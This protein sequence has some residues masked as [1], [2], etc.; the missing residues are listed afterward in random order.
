MSRKRSCTSS[1]G[2][3]TRGWWRPRPT[4]DS[5]WRRFG[6]SSRMSSSAS[7]RSSTAS[8]GRCR[9]SPSTHGNPSVRCVRRSAP[10]PT[11]SSSGP[12]IAR[13]SRR[14]A[15]DARV[16][17]AALD[18]RAT[19]IAVHASRGGAGATFVATHLARAFARRG[20]STVLIDADLVYGEVGAAVGAPD[21][22]VHTLADLVPLGAELTPAHLDETFWTHP[23]AFR[24]LLS[25]PA[26]EAPSIEASFLQRVVDVAATSTDVVILHLPHAIDAY[27]RAGCETADRIVEVLTLDVLSF[28]S[29]K[30]ALDV[31]RPLRDRGTA[32]VRREPRIA[33]RDHAEGRQPRVR[34]RA[35]GGRAA[36]SGRDPCA[37]PRSSRSGARTDGSRVRSSRSGP[38]AGGGCVEAQPPYYRARPRRPTT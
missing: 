18:R 27:A 8:P 22:D 16:G 7:R 23:E 19:V 36:R 4:I 14:A 2:A 15:A 9:S 10:A 11:A 24:V 6:N 30:R 5:C 32:R 25:P 26:V 12:P 17:P 20:E 38:R 1:I 34:V 33:R 3:D 28:R 29:A 37:R 21:E 31:L 13:R 35:A